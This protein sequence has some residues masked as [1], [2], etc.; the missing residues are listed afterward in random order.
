MTMTNVKR[1]DWMTDKEYDFVYWYF[2]CVCD[3][4]MK[5]EDEKDYEEWCKRVLNTPRFKEEN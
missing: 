5:W 2:G 3:Y 4:E 1:L